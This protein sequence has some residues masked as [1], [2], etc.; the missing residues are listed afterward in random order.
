MKTLF[1]RLC[2]R[3]DIW[4]LLLL[5]AGH[6]P[7]YRHAGL[8]GILAAHI[9]EPRRSSASTLWIVNASILIRRSVR[10]YVYIPWRY[11]SSRAKWQLSGAV[12]S[13]Q[14]G[15]DATTFSLLCPTRNRPRS[16]L[17]MIESVCRTASHPERVEL[18]F[19]VDSDDP[20][21]QDYRNLFASVSRRFPALRRCELIVGE[22]MTV[23]KL[24]N[25]LA[26][27]SSGDVLMMGNDDQVYVDYAWDSRAATALTQYP[28]RVVCMCLDVGQYRPKVDFNE[29]IDAGEGLLQYPD[30]VVC[31]D[32]NHGRQSRLD[33]PMVTRRWFD[34]LEQ[35]APEIFEFWNHDLWLLDI[36]VRLRRL[37][38]IRDTLVD[39][40]HYGQYLA[41]FD[42][43]YRRHCLN[44]SRWERDQAL[45]R[46]TAAQREAAA[47]KLRQLIAAA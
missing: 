11:V 27:A 17:T 42:A 47:G 40:L 20:A 13:R 38:P 33:F 26:R 10:R 18:L 14:A 32:V 21:L 3:L 19:Y 9:L 37:H 12:G 15:A 16:S 23:G 43:T 29:V 39:H 1:K 30:G 28:D 7:R 44:W 25:V 8:Q 6:L 24:W 5:L 46:E 41:P 35:F 36:A 45:F 2:Q 34:A 31:M 22:S 4:D